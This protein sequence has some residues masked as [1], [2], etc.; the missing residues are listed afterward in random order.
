[1][2]CSPR[3]SGTKEAA[4]SKGR[5]AGVEGLQ[6]DWRICWAGLRCWGRSAQPGCLGRQIKEPLNGH[7]APDRRP[8]DVFYGDG[9]VV[10]A[11]PVV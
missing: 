10:V 4:Q 9:L 6:L 2:D 11:D 5:K 8:R 3:G 7:E 1:M